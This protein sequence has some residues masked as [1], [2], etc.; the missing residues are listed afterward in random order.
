VS[1]LVVVLSTELYAVAEQGLERQFR[2][3]RQA[4]FGLQGPA[5]QYILQ[6]PAV[7]TE[8]TAEQTTEY[9]L[10]KGKYGNLSKFL[11]LAGATPSTVVRGGG[12]SGRRKRR[13]V[14]H[15]NIPSV[16]SVPET[17]TEYVLP[18][19]KYGNLSKFLALAGATPSTVVRGGGYSG[20]RKRRQVTHANIPSV[21]SVPETTT[22]YVLPKGKYGNLS[23]FLALAGA[24]PSTVVRGGSYSGRRKREETRDILT[25]EIPDELPRVKD[26]DGP[27]KE[28]DIPLSSVKVKTRGNYGLSTFLEES[29]RVSDGVF[30]GRYSLG[31]GRRRRQVLQ[32]DF[33][34]FSEYETKRVGILTVEQNDFLALDQRLKL[35]QKAKINLDIG[36]NNQAR[37]VRKRHFSLK[38][39]KSLQS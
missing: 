1:L 16:E 33:I 35:E 2:T 20:R 28:A 30:R 3:V 14:T 22:E 5:G 12:Y 31:Y 34:P 19:G 39:Q 27:K 8:N 23:K 13:Q 18:K 38:N 17:T 6:Q 7:T 36:H 26:V 9:V 10:P 15:A 4:Q 37:N 29:A 24:T 11:A 21:E 25:N 32:Q